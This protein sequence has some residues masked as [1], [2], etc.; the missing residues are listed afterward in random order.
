M[1]QARVLIESF[2]AHEPDGHFYLLL[3]DGLPPQ[4]R[5]D[6]R[7]HLVP[8]SE[9]PTDEYP[10]LCFEYN[11]DELCAALKPWLLSVLL[12]RYGERQVLLLDPE[13]L[14]L[15]PLAA[16][17]QAL[18]TANLLLTPNFV[19]PAPMLDGATE[20]E[21]LLRV[22]AFHPGVLGV[23]AGA[24]TARC[25]AWWAER[26][27][28]GCHVD[29]A[30]GLF[31]DQKWLDLAPA[32]FDGVA[33]LR[34]P[35]YGVTSANL[36]GRD[37][38]LDSGQYLVNGRPLVCFRFSSLDPVERRVTGASGQS[39]TLAPHS[40]LKRLIDAYAQRCLDQGYHR[41]AGRP[42]PYGAL[43]NGVPVH[44]LLRGLYGGLP[45]ATRRAF[46]D[47]FVT[48]PPGSFWR[49]ATAMRLDLHGL[50]PFLVHLHRARP[51]VAA[52][53]PQV[54]GEHRAAFVHW[55][56][57]H[58]VREHGYDPRLVELDHFDTEP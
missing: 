7:V 4:E 52:V 48:A 37:L 19:A 47:P 41:L 23:R 43:D 58:G 22:G 54:Q 13:L 3:V 26:L 18:A 38:T 17:R 53:Y 20:D 42:Y 10:Q 25:L 55:A 46:G 51:D 49:W 11:A 44:P 35:A 28:H 56:Q 40:P 16:A 1:A 12:D 5:L 39:L 15:Q 9:L 21:L 6:R 33:V 45:D 50:T 36:Y 14:I 2:F 57:T 31:L 8:P 29:P 24:E 30:R 34:D 32:L 27:R